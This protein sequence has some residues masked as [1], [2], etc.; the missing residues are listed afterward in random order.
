MDKV[1]VPVLF[2]AGLYLGVVLFSDKQEAEI[3]TEMKAKF[4]NEK[5]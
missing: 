4:H 3:L 1:K 2:G 5:G